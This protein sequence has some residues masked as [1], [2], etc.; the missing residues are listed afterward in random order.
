MK[1]RAAEAAKAI[2][3]ELKKEFPAVKFSVKSQTYSGGSSVDV[4]WT[5]GP[6]TDEVDTILGKYEYGRFNG[7]EDM[8][9][10]TNVRKDIP[11]AK[12][13]MSHRTMSA[14]VQEELSGYVAQNYQGAQGV[15]FFDYIQAQK[16]YF[17][18]LVYRIF[19]KK[20]FL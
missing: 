3:Q 1:T 2:K 18:T 7:M 11:Q 8:Y 5:D 10:M 9:E 13:V 4:S 12:Y 17:N 15:G 6:T 16:E 19:C 14:K 20:S